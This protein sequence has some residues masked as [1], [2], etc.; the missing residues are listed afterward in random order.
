MTISYFE[1]ERRRWDFGNPLKDRCTGHRASRRY[2]G[3]CARTG[4]DHGCRR[5]PGHRR[6]LR[7]RNRR[8]GWTLRQA[9]IE[10]RH[11]LHRRRWRDTAGGRVQQRADRCHVWSPRG[12]LS[13]FQGRT[14]AHHRGFLYGRPTGLLV[15]AGLLIDHAAAGSQRQDRGVFQQQLREPRRSL[16]L[17]KALPARTQTDANRQRGC[18]LDTRLLGCWRRSSDDR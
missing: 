7:H 15:R 14:G 8:E 16:G 11:C 13:L 5:W 18:H 1:N 2:R 17:A 3:R 4:C 12:I 9:W 6:K 10:A